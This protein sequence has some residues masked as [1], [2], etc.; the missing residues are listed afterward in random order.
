MIGTIRKHAT[1]LWA[2]LIAAVIVSFV[3][4]FTPTAKLRD[5]SGGRQEVFGV[6]NGHPI[7][8]QQYVEAWTEVQL[9]FFM[10][11]LT[12]PERAELKKFRF[13][14]ARETR[15]RLVLL[16]KLRELDV[17]V[18]EGAM[19][20]WITERF[21]DPKTPGSAK[22]TYQGFV[23]HELPRH[24]VSAGE[25]QRFIEHQIGIDHLVAV[26]S[27]PGKLV[28]PRE[29]AEL[30]R[31]EN[32]KVE[33]EAVVFSATNFQSGVKLEPGALAQ[34]YTNRQSFYRIPER[35]QVT[36]VKFP[37]SNYLVQANQALAKI[38]NLDAE[39]DR[40][41]DSS[42]PGFFTDTNGQVMPREAAK[43]KIKQDMRGQQ[44][45]FAARRQA[46]LFATELE[47]NQPVKA[48]NLKNLAAARGLVSGDTEP[49]DE[50]GP[51]GL[52]AGTAFSQQ[53]FKLTPDRPFSPQTIKAEDGIYLIALKQKLASEVP[54]LE[55]IRP[56]VT[57]DY[58]RDQGRQLAR[59]VGT[60]FY[61]LLTNRLARGGTFAEACA[62]VKVTPL[63]LPRFSAKTRNLPD[64]DRR[65]DLGLVKATASPL[66]AGKTSQFV[67]TYDG[68]FVLHVKSRTP[69][70]ET[71]VKKELPQFLADLRQAQQVD[72]FY[73]WFG[74]QMEL[75]RIDTGPIKDEEE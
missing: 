23:Q 2:F 68:G 42:G 16:E 31:Q 62:A 11:Y 71:E 9:N 63:N 56:K 66:P 5:R 67:N 17:R 22:A 69:V 60:N 28:P 37:A 50:D 3:I 24:N 32:E 65:L 48:E 61:A 59:Q 12:W 29:A 13:S 41:Y 14:I 70:A 51:P 35:V 26:A 33:A 10:R 1:W 20:E 19:A 43:A 38:T 18:D 58:L 6:M 25:F 8:R 55:M 40:R 46:A 73:E 44:A 57:D 75:S 74:K 15:G 52:K 4:Y 54:P 21:S 64:W 27:I 34:F 49:F 47:T 53:A 30:Y 36:Y 45:L 7:T 39:I 72:S